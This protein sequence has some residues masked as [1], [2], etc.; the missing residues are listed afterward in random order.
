MIV[1]PMNPPDPVRFHITARSDN[2][3]TGPLVVTTSGKQTC[4]SGCPFFVTGCYAAG[5]PLAIHWAKISAGDRGLTWA[6]FLA[7]LKAALIRSPFKIWRHNQAGDLPGLGNKIDRRAVLQLAKASK[8]AGKTGFTYSHK[9]ILPGQDPA[10]RANLATIKAAI[11]AGLIVNASANNLQHADKIADLGLPVCVTVPE[12]TPERFTTPAGRRGIVCPAQTRD[13]I[14]CATC[15][16]CSRPGR[17]VL[18]GFRFHGSQARKA[19]INAA[20]FSPTKK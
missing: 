12:S 16:L 19:E 14:S 18:I 13:N 7:D 5:G 15:G 10:A 9:P 3:K 20:S 8:A 11:A 17:A 4:W 6:D 1:D 2:Q